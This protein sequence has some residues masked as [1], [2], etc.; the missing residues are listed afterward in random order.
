[1]PRTPSTLLRAA[2]VATLGIAAA[3]S[4]A[5]SA[6]L[7][8]SPYLSFADSPFNGGSFS[9]FHLEDFEDGSL[10]TPGVTAS[11]GF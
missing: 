10:N 3:A 2:A 7:G 6:F 4:T 9:Y 11:A 5:R 1:M 8:P